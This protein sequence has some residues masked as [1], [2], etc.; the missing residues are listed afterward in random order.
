MK[1]FN[2]VSV[3]DRS[4]ISFSAVH[5]GSLI[6]FWALHLREQTGRSSEVTKYE[7]ATGKAL[8]GLF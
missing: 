4:Q 3:G 5:S 8:G 7:P 6:I 1:F 2:L